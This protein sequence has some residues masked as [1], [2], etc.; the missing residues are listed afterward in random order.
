MWRSI[1]GDERKFVRRDGR[2]RPALRSE[3]EWGGS[4]A[5]AVAATSR[6]FRSKLPLARITVP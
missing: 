2:S 4:A 3:N 6:A 1:R 5:V